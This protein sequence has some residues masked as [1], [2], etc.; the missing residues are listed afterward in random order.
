MLKACLF[1]SES[2]PGVVPFA[3][4]EQFWQYRSLRYNIGCS[5]IRGVSPALVIVPC[6][7]KSGSGTVH[8]VSTGYRVGRV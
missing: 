3:A 8:C 5:T 2:S 6:Q 7:Y 4:S 1:S